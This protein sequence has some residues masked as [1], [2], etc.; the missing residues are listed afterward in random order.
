[1]ITTTTRT[2]F[3]ALEALSGSSCYPNIDYRTLRHQDTSDPHETLR[4]RCYNVSRHF[5]TSAEVDTKSLQTLQHRIEEKLGQ[6]GLW[7]IP[8]RY[9]STG[10]SASSWCRS[11][12]TLWHQVCSAEMSCGRNVRLSEITLRKLITRKYFCN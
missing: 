11:V 9:S 3:V 5:G 12:R 10:D 1:M 4:H 6:F 7:T 2:S 8:T